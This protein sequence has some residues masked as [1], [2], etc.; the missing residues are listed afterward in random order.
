MKQ[1]NEFNDEHPYL[2]AILFILAIYVAARLL[3]IHHDADPKY[4]SW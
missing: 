4:K 2:F 1:L 3:G